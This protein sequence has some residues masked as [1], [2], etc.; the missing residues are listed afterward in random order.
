MKKDIKWLVKMINEEL[1]ILQQRLVSGKGTTSQKTFDEGRGWALSHVLRMMYYP[2]KLEE[3]SKELPV[4]PKYVADEF[5]YDKNPHWE[6]DESKDVS[7]ILKCAFGNEGKPSEFLDWVRGNPEDYVMAVRN[8]Y[9]VEEEQKYY[10]DLD[11]VAY[12]A[13]LNG[14]DHVDIYSDS[15]SGSD[16]LEFHL[17]EQEIKNYDERFWP[18]AVKVEKENK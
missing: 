10:V 12:V 2:D 1:D 11:D 16:E 13:K 3:L 18:F 14:N 4:I 7:H 9:E 8:G 17:T 15:I 6:V 5:D